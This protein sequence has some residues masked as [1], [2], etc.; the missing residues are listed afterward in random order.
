M[1]FWLVLA[2][3]AVLGMFVPVLLIGC[4]AFLFGPWKR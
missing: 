2:C 1:N 4:W 3:G